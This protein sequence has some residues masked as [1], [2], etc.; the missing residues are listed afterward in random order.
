MESF[1]FNSSLILN[2]KKYGSHYFQTQNFEIGLFFHS[3]A[4]RSSDDTLFIFEKDNSLLIGVA[5]GAGGHPR[6]ADASFAIASSIQKD[7]NKDSNF[8]LVRS[9]QAANQAVLDLKCGARSTLNFALI[10]NESYYNLNVGDSELIHW[11]TKKRC[12]FKSTPQTTPG[13]LFKAE[14]IDSEEN[15]EHPLRSQVYHLLGDTNL[16][17]ESSIITDLKQGHGLL[18]ASDGIHDNYTAEDLIE[19][20]SGPEFEMQFV[21]FCGHLAHQ[22]DAESLRSMDDCSLIVLRKKS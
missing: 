9:L 10:E 17:C 14:E 13:L 6:G 12:I 18:I 5:D 20:F 8:D 15:L 22:L 1:T 16:T 21:N 4:D 19:A 3:Y 11:N 7:F 2:E